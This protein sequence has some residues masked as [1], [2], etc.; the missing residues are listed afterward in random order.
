MFS[1]HTESEGINIGFVLYNNDQFFRSQVFQPSL[2]IKRKVIA[3]YPAKEN[4]LD[5]VEF[6]VR[7]QV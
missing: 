1:L 7:D 5:F 6:T 3:G 4:V 2:N